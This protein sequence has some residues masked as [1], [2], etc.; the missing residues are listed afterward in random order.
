MDY[1][2]HQLDLSPLRLADAQ[3]LDCH[4]PAIASNLAEAATQL[5]LSRLEE[6]LGLLIQ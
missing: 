5:G 1:I 3:D 2:H 4:L 6:G